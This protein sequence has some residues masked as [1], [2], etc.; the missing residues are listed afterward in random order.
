MNSPHAPGEAVTGDTTAPEP[1]MTVGVDPDGIVRL[2]WAAGT[3]ITQEYA[4]RSV[5]VV[6][7]VGGGRRLP[8][9]VDISGING[10]TRAARGVYAGDSSIAALALVGQTPMV[11]VIANF[12]LSVTRPAVPSRF[13]ADDEEAVRWLRGYLP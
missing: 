4:R 7:E 9:L 2:R 10:L 11:R 5:E 3:T 12:S 1:L 8:L 13:F 6:A